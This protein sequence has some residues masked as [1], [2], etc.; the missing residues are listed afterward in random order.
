[1]ACGI[2]ISGVALVW[3]LS[4]S[5]G[6][7]ANSL[8]M[9][10][11]QLQ[12]WVNRA[13]DVLASRNRPLT[14]IGEAIDIGEILQSLLSYLGQLGN[15]AATTLFI[16]VTII[17]ALVEAPTL[18]LTLQQS[19]GED[20]A[21]V[22]RSTEFSRSVV[23][24]FGLRTLVN[25]LTGAIV[26]VFLWMLGVDFALLWGVLT[27]FLSYV[28]YLGITLATI[29]SVLLALVEYGV[30]MAVVVII[31]IIIINGVAENLLAP[32]LIGQGL[33]ISPLIVFLSFIL[34][35][36][37]LGPLGMFL[38]MPLTVI[39][40]FLLDSFE[41]TRWAANLMTGQSNSSRNSGDK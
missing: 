23:H 27:F 8:S 38:S 33:K 14:G 25:L 19:L 40:M 9:Y 16:I 28:P 35:S 37:I 26:T 20:H 22:T 5:F 4:V 11:A 13:Q 12:E 29:P 15:F 24:Y 30:G 32:K 3:F 10:Q 39:L 17:F 1:M 6:Q 34:W 7:L 2:V 36:W 18:R 31:G 21:L 41:S